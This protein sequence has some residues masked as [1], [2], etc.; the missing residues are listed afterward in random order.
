ME[1]VEKTKG[2][3][4]ERCIEFGEGMNEVEMLRKAGKG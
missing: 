4:L 2:N 3:S 1:A